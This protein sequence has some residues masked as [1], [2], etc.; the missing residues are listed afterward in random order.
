MKFVIL[1]LLSLNL[2]PIL[3]GK[4]VFER[5]LSIDGKVYTKEEAQEQINLRKNP[6]IGRGY[7]NLGYATDWL[8]AQPWGKNI[9]TRDQSQLKRLIVQNSNSKLKF[10]D[11]KWSKVLNQFET[12]EESLAKQE[13]TWIRN[14]P[15]FDSVS[16]R[17][18][19]RA[20]KF[21]KIILMKS[22]HIWQ[23]LEDAFVAVREI[24][25]EHDVKLTTVYPFSILSKYSF[26]EPIKISVIEGTNPLLVIKNLNYAEIDKCMNYPTEKNSVKSLLNLMTENRFDKPRY[27]NLIESDRENS[28]DSI[29]WTLDGTKKLFPLDKSTNFDSFRELVEKKYA[30]NF[31][32]IFGATGVRSAA[33]TDCSSITMNRNQIFLIKTYKNSRFDPKAIKSKLESK[34]IKNQL[35]AFD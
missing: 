30:I 18:K 19:E 15:S 34:T 4:V 6:K 26:R 32:E 10:L 16:K 23:S 11:N 25:N 20:K 14:L 1:I 9:L 12:L 35:D 24:A 29:Y 17:A 2:F 31:K 13:E 5:L 3:Y 28:V 33:L 27:L 8:W 22:L 7:W 21:D